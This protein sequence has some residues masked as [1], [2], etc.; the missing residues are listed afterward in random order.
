MNKKP[1]SVIAGIGAYLPDEVITSRNVDERLNNFHYLNVGDMLENITGVK[2]RRYAS[3]GMQASDL[4]VFAAREALKNSGHNPLD[5]ETILYASCSRDLCEPATASIVQS[6]L[7]ALNAKRVIDIANACSSFCSAL[8]MMDALISTGKSTV[9]LVVSG[10]RLSTVVNWN[11]K[12]P[13]ELKTGFAALTLGDGGGAFILTENSKNENR[14]VVA[15]HFFS[16]GREWPLSVVMGGGT[17]SPRNNIEDTYFKCDSIRLNRL[18]LKYI[19]DVIEHVLNMVGWKL[20]DLDLVVPHQVS[21]SVIKK[22]AKR[23]KY[24][25]EKISVTL[26]RYGNIGAASIPIALNEAIKEGRVG[27]GSRVLLAAGAAGFSAGAI[28]IVL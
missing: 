23:F 18:A 20:K 19:P 14:G 15:S 12:N 28:L 13:S 4:A 10:E 16:D 17:I 26:E 5:I 25:M 8:E 7:G 21:Y 11:L 22:I 6:K 24:P 3:D 9:G 27:E 2:E 1:M